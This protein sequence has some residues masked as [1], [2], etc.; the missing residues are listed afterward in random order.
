MEC[1]EW[2][3]CGVGRTLPIDKG[4]Q[5]LKDG[6]Y[7]GEFVPARHDGDIDIMI[8]VRYVGDADDAA[9]EDV[10]MDHV[11]G[12]VVGGEARGAE[13]VSMV[14]DESCLSGAGVGEGCSVGVE[15]DFA[16]E[17]DARL[18]LLR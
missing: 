6:W 17:F 18:S 5:K 10:G 7:F 15:F 1:A 12:G 14:S 13:D 16:A 9:Y 4:G 3:Y 8:A 2:M 11:A